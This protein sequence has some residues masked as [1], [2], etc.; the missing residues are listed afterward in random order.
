MIAKNSRLL[1]LG[2]A[3][4]AVWTVIGYRGATAQPVSAIRAETGSIV[5]ATD[6]FLNSLDAAQREKVQFPFA[7]Q[8]TATAAT[9]S[10]SGAG[11]GPGGGPPREV[12][13]FRKRVPVAW[14]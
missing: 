12:P 14:E 4:V 6:A 11:G 8:K 3:G 5:A 10:R 13:V 1:I 2:V 7:L 9:F